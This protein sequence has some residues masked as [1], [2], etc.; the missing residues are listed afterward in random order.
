MKVSTMYE[1]NLRCCTKNQ[2]GDPIVTDVDKSHGGSGV[3]YSPVDM[4][5]VSLTSCILSVMA[6]IA[7]QQG[8]GIKGA[9]LE[10]DYEMVE[11]PVHRIGKIS[12]NLSL[13]AGIPQEKRAILEK[14]IKMC[15]VH[16]SLSHE[17]G[18]DVKVTYAG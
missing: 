17:I 11:K 18:Y 1:G 7:W 9:K 8:V 10:A 3:A 6:L 5:V 16:N 12:L 4:L 15:P 2:N 14:A 13:P